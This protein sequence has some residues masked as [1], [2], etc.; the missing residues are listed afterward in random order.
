MD[1]N[2]LDPIVINAQFAEIEAQRTEALT[3][4][5]R[6]AGRVAQLEAQVAELCKMLNEPQEPPHPEPLEDQQP[7]PPRRRARKTK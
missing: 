1:P 2:Q 5:A 4:A 6:Y 3:R 7:P